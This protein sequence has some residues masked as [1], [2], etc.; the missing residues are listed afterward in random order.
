MARMFPEY[1][2]ELNSCVYDKISANIKVDYSKGI[3]GMAEA[4]QQVGNFANQ[5]GLSFEQLAA[6]VGRVM[7]QTRQ[8]GVQIGT[9][10]KTIMTRISKAN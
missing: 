1:E 5:A 8:E 2:K 6:I 3:Q 9:A 7:Q 10:L 4:V